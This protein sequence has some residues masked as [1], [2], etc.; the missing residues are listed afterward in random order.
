[1]SEAE[2]L[3]CAGCGAA[4]SASA[5]FCESCG[6]EQVVQPAVA[7]GAIDPESPTGAT[8]SA[9]STTPQAA[10]F[11]QLLR[12]YS[13]LPGV[14]FAA[15]SALIGSAI[16]L[17]ASFLLAIAIPSESFI[18][19]SGEDSSDLLRETLMYAT[20]TTLASFELGFDGG[21]LSIRI[22]P[23]LFVLFPIGGCAL[24][25]NFMATRTAGLPSSLRYA[26]GAGVSIPF[27]LAMLVLSLLAGSLSDANGSLSPAEGSVLVLS[28][29]WGAVGGIGGTAWAL[30][31]E[32]PPFAAD[33][34]ID[35]SFATA[36]AI[37][38]PLAAS[39]A[40]LSLFAV[41]LWGVQ[42]VRDASEAREDRSLA[43]AL[44][45]DVLFAGDLGY[46]YQALGTGAELGLFNEDFAGAVLATT[47]IDDEGES[48][49]A[50]A[51][52]LPI[53]IAQSKSEK[54]IE[55]QGVDIL[56]A[57][58]RVFDYGNV[59]PAWAFAPILAVLLIVPAF[60]A[61]YA[62]FAVS[63]ANGAMTSLAGAAWGALVGPLWAL[64]LALLNS[65]TQDLGF[66]QV[67]GDSL[68]VLTLFV[69]SA[70]GALGG[71]GAVQ[72]R[73]TEPA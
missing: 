20:T 56:G 57:E 69:G 7:E 65:L 19:I 54:L 27:A 24:G 12:D 21:E 22:A 13:Q 39:L 23:L 72:Q 33:S 40:I 10:D 68:F 70:L 49:G 60:F 59:L 71:V 6:T 4:I 43:T 8:A 51:R 3:R 2:T 31:G 61:L 34:P 48:G 11:L 29:L 41:L 53:P 26:W 46:R 44:V 32:A 17:A 52:F 9:G 47:S 62:G 67:D 55:E 73:A 42:I 14:Q 18:D 66:G 58:F 35:R 16:V 25:A 50:V 38:R 36:S 5:R 30:R 63:R 64:A 15:L 28:L 37:F 45:D 1:M